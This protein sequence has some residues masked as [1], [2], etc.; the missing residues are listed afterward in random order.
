M[1]YYSKYDEDVN[2]FELDT[3]DPKP[4]NEGLVGEVFSTGNEVVAKLPVGTLLSVIG[5][6]ELEVVEIPEPEPVEAEPGDRIQ[7]KKYGPATVVRKSVMLD[8]LLNEGEFL[9]VA[10]ADPVVRRAYASDVTFI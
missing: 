2:D 6:G 7:T 5:Q 10:D 4:V 3:V 1:S 9:Y 8:I